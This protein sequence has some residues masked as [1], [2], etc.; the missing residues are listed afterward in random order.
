MRALLLATPLACGE[1]ISDMPPRQAMFEPDPPRPAPRTP[2]T[3]EH[4]YVPPADATHVVDVVFS[5]KLDDQLVLLDTTFVVDDGLF[6][7]VEGQVDAAVS[8]SLSLSS[9]NHSLGLIIHAVGARGDAKRY[10][11]EIKSSHA[12]GA[13]TTRIDA[14]FYVDP[15]PRVL[16][17]RPK[18]TWHDAPP[19]DGG[20]GP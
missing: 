16:Q 12:I 1:P 10:K 11:F 17:D 2:N 4:A 7:R 5:A 6:W 15:V 13:S 18:V 9:A 3:P 19:G 14:I 20:A 8:K